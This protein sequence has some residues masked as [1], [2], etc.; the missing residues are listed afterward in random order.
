MKLYRFLVLVCAILYPAALCFAQQPTEPGQPPVNPAPGAGANKPSGAA[1]QVPGAAAAGKEQPGAPVQ[2]GQLAAAGPVSLNLQSAL[3][4]ARAYSQQF[5][6][7]TIA[8]AT[9]REDVLQARAAFFPTLSYFNQYI[10]TQGNG[11]PSGVFVANDGVH[12]YN[13][14]AAVHAEL[15][16]LTNRALYRRAMFAQAA[17]QAKQEIAQRGLVATVVGAYYGMIA[18]ERHVSNAQKSLTEAQQFLDITQKQESGGEAAHADVIKAQLTVEQRRRDLQDAQLNLEKARIS[19]GVVL[20]PNMNQEFTIQ[21]DLAT[22]GALPSRSEVESM[23]TAR[24]PDV[25]AAEATLKSASY[26]V[27]AAKGAYFPSLV[28]DYWYGIDANVFGIYGPDHRRNLGSVAQGTLN[29]PVW[30]WG[31]TRSRVRQAELAEQQARVD[32]TYAQRNLQSE[33]SQSYLE[34]QTALAELN[35]LKRSVDLATE[36]LRLTILRYQAGEATALE[37]SD[38]QSTLATARNAYD[39]GLARYRVALAVIQTLT[40]TL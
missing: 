22:L 1:G 26:G 19:L 38:A 24:S 34:A 39:D 5:Q 13:S 21:D 14:Q 35:S 11:T 18:A 10:Y 7:A 27:S 28:V 23:A 29:I 33:I 30:N 4:L 31:V 20:F 40:G 16:S 2:P 6:S 12:I 37:V 25:R 8:T 15:F 17:A 3:D 32:L 36:S 9:A